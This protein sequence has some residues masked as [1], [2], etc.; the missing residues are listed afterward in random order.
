MP[1]LTVVGVVAD[2]RHVALNALAEP[3]IYVPDTQYSYLRLAY[4]V[5]R[6]ETD[7]RAWIPAIRDQLRAVDRTV[8]VFPSSTLEERLSAFLLPWKFQAAL[9]GVFAGLALILAAVGIYGFLCQAVN[10]R[11]HEIAVRIALGARRSEVIR[12]AAGQGLLLA[13]MGI[14]LGLGITVALARYLESLLFGVSSTDSLTYLAISVLALC[15]AALA[16]WIPAR[17]AAAM[18]PAEMLRYAE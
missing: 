8:P 9:I 10:R 15:V 13:S 5:V 7:P 18:D 14:V 2:I 16:S 6:T 4:L 12:L 3:E 11:R 17:R 1:W